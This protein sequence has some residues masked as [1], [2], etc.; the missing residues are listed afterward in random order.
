M[1][2]LK[3]IF[4]ALA[5]VFLLILAQFFL[6]IVRDLFRGSFIFL[7]PFVVFCLLGISLTFLT[8]RQKIKGKL[9]VF[10]LLTG[11]SSAGFFVFVFLHNAFYALGSLTRDIVFLF[12]LMG[13]FDILSFIIA[14]FVCPVCFL[15]G[16]IGTS[17]YLRNN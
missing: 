3:I 11:F 9:K 5:I 7:A 15:V 17:L 8:L 10:L 12:Y 14:L 2:N 16:L 13:I 1:K 4:I 6:P